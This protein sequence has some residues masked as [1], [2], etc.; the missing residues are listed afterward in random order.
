MCLQLYCQMFKQPKDCRSAMLDPMGREF[1]CVSGSLWRFSCAPW[2]LNMVPKFA[3]YCINFFYLANL[4]TIFRSHG[5]H[6][7]RLYHQICISHTKYE[8]RLHKEQLKNP[9]HLTKLKQTPKEYFL[10][11]VF[12]EHGCTTSNL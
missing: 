5:A 11:L 7:K 9:F 12:L 8:N 4:G 3:T 2:L 1:C 6:E 10:S